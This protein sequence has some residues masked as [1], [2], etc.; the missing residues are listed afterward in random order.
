ML[1]MDLSDT[2][3]IFMLHSSIFGQG[4]Q[5]NTAENILPIVAEN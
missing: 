5:K 3:L 4:G 2:K 1:N